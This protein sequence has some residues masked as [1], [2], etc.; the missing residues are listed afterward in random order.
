MASLQMQFAQSSEN[1]SGFSLTFLEVVENAI[2]SFDDF[3]QFLPGGG[4]V[5]V[6]CW[7]PE[8]PPMRARRAPQFPPQELEGGARR[9]PNF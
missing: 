2:L 1:G 4:G 7:G 9:A 3:C 6:R 5:V 8:G